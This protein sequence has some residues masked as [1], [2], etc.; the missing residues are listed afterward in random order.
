MQT[1]QPM[2]P[3]SIFTVSDLYWV[4]TTDID[5]SDS[6]IVSHVK[7]RRNLPSIRIRCSDSIYEQISFAVENFAIKSSQKV[8][9]LRCTSRRYKERGSSHHRNFKWR[10]RGQP[11]NHHGQPMHHHELSWAMISLTPIQCISLDIPKIAPVSTPYP[12]DTSKFQF[13]WANCF[14]SCFWVYAYLD[15]KCCW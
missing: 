2:V 6:N 11:M 13:M 8:T 7:Y 1:A 15:G 5:L 9:T 4:S 12:R 14:G 10:F 3:W